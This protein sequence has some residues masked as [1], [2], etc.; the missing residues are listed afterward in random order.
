MANLYAHV[1]PSR[2]F[3]DFFRLTYDIIIFYRSRQKIHVL[4]FYN[5]NPL[6]SINYQ[7]VSLNGTCISI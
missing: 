7:D 6:F 1:I 2:Q 5:K 4:V 3:L